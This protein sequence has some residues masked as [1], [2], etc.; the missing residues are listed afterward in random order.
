[1]NPDQQLQQQQLPMMLTPNNNNPWNSNGSLNDQIEGI[2][3]Q[4]AKL[5]DQIVQSEKNLQA[6]H[7]VLDYRTFGI[8]MGS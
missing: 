5:R 7:Q 4:Q 8:L 1:M 6:Q 2:N 3:Q